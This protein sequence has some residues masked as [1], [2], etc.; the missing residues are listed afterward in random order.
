VN[1]QLNQVLYFLLGK[2]DTELPRDI[3]R[4]SIWLLLVAFALSLFRSVIEHLLGRL[5]GRS[6]LS[7][8]DESLFYTAI[9][10]IVC[11]TLKRIYNWLL[12]RRVQVTDDSLSILTTSWGYAG[13]VLTLG[14]VCWG[15]LRMLFRLSI[16]DA[17]A[18]QTVLVLI[19]TWSVTGPS[20]LSRLSNGSSG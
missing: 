8:V 12:G 5:R 14:T 1:P 7:T 3:L 6:F 13:C 2:E 4:D 20:R 16:E 19:F 18:T 17:F 9:I 15:L 10:A 11:R